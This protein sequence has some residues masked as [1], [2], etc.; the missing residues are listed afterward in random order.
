MSNKVNDRS[1][2]SDGSQNKAAEHAVSQLLRNNLR[3]ATAN[4]HRALDH[5]PILSP[6]LRSPLST[7]A[8]ILALR[9]LHG[10]QSALETMLYGF[11]P[12]EAFPGRA[13]DLER[14]L[15]RLDVKPYPVLVTVPRATDYATKMGAM[16]VIEGSNLG[17]QVI[18]RQLA[19]TLSPELPRDFFGR[20]EGYA[21]WERFWEFAMQYLAEDNIA[22]A[23][24]MAVDVF[25]FYR[26]HLNSV[27]QHTPIPD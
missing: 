12:R 3:E 20:A 13:A 21:R 16:Y 6:L 2:D 11:A 4:A 26:A 25:D 17:G 10:P 18:A 1:V 9:A 14:D 23:S 7:E 22:K 5:H 8:Y 19:Q 27:L 24:E 15:A